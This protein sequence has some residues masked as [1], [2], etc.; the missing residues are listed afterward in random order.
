MLFLTGGGKTLAVVMAIID[1]MG[2]G[3]A[4][5]HAIYDGHDH[6]NNSPEP[7]ANWAL[8]HQRWLWKSS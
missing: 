6:C 5:A 7:F 1:G 3:F 4:T 2:M 8:S